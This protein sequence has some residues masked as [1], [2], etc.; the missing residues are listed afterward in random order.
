M[1]CSETRNVCIQCYK[2]INS[3]GPK[4]KVDTFQIKY[5]K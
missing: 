5:N 3:N 2:I 1:Y 4:I